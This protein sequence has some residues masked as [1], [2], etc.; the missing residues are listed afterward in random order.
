MFFFSLLESW[1]LVSSVTNFNLAWKTATLITLVTRKYSDLTLLQFEDQY[2]F[3]Q[4][5]DAIFIPAVGGKM[6]QMG[7]FSTT[8]SY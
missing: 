5:H 3:L 6:D 1:A 8:N 7:H 4:H 2:F